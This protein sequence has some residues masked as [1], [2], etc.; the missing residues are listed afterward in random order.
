MRP[1]NGEHVKL[2]D[3]LW[4]SARLTTSGLGQLMAAASSQPAGRIGLFN[5]PSS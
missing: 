5:T 2:Q 1:L 4:D 3:T